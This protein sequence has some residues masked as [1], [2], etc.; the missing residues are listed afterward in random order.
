MSADKMPIRFGLE[1]APITVGCMAVNFSCCIKQVGA[2][3]DLTKDGLRSGEVGQMKGSGT[4]ARDAAASAGLPTVFALHELLVHDF[5]ESVPQASI[6]RLTTSIGALARFQGLGVNSSLT[7]VGF[8]WNVADALARYH[9]APSLDILRRI[10]FNSGEAYEPQLSGPFSMETIPAAPRVGVSTHSL[11]GRPNAPR[12]LRASRSVDQPRETT[13]LG[14]GDFLQFLGASA[15]AAIFTVGS[16]RSRI[17]KQVPGEPNLLL[18]TFSCGTTP[19]RN[20]K[21]L[22]GGVQAEVFSADAGDKQAVVKLSRKTVLGSLEHER[23][24]LKILNDA[25]VPNVER[26]MGF[27]EITTTAGPRQGMVLTPCLPG[28][29]SRATE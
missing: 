26:C 1:A 27:G 19:L 22:G 6:P 16:L 18:N 17:R 21:Y 12:S 4:E 29:A 20:P 7:A 3:F 5:M 28:S 11:S 23:K 10:R 25:K 15:A 13:S 8:L 2:S 24:I 14:R 9:C